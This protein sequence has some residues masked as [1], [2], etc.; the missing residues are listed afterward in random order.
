MDCMGFTV[1]QFAEVDVI[2]LP[3]RVMMADAP[4]IRTDIR[5][6]VERGRKNIVLDLSDVA[7]IDS[8]GLSVLIS[9][10]DATQAAGGDVLLL[11]P[12]SIVRS[13]I[14][15]TRLQEVFEIFGSEEHAV[16]RLASTNGATAVY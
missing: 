9:A 14:E 13:L 12:T 3:R 16:Q 8:S 7:F 10:R 5:K 2:R 1:E 15:L 11:N 4:S 6:M